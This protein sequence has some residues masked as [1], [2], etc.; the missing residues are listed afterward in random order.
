MINSKKELIGMKNTHI[1][2][3]TKSLNLH[4]YQSSKIHNILTEK[5]T[6]YNERINSLIQ[7]KIISKKTGKEIHTLKELSKGKSY[8]IHFIDG[9]TDIKI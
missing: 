6:E 7:P 4:Q 5:I 1:D 3:H 8:R 9:Y 2:K